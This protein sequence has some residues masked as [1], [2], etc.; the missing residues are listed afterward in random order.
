MQCCAVQ[1]HDRLFF[2]E[3]STSGLWFQGIPKKILGT[4][5]TSFHYT[6]WMQGVQKSFKGFLSYY[7]QNRAANLGYALGIFAISVLKMPSWDLNLSHIY[8]FNFYP[9]APQEV[10]I[11]T[12]YCQISVGI[13]LVLLH[14]IHR[15]SV[16]SVSTYRFFLGVH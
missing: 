1:I 3:V 11:R 7:H 2:E 9:L 4:F 6:Y 16:L 14:S 12:T 8:I 5:D 15:C 13:F 10:D